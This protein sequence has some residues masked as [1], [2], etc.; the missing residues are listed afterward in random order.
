M[1]FMI[2]ECWSDASFKILGCYET[3]SCQGLMPLLTATVEEVPFIDT[4]ELIYI[5]V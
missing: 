3:L 1:F 4:R 5:L 2:L